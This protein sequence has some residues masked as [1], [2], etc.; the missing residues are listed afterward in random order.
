[1]KK[2]LL[3]EL[4]LREKIG[5]MLLPYQYHIYCYEDSSVKNIY[6]EKTNFTNLRSEEEVKEYIQKENF[7]TFYFEQTNFL[8]VTHMDLTDSA[9]SK[10][11]SADFKKFIM[12]QDSYSNIPA[13]MSG[14]FEREGA[15]NRF[16]DLSVVCP[17][18]AVGAT[19]SEE[20][21]YQLGAQIAKEIRS[22]GAN[23]RWAPVVDICHRF[24]A[25]SMRTFSPD[26]PDKLIRLANAHIKGMQDNGV[27]ATAKHFPGGDRYDYRDAHISPSVISSDMDEWWREQGKIFKGV[28]DAGVYSV[29]ISHSGFPAVDDSILKGNFRPA[30][31]S[32]KIV[33]DLLKGELGFKGVAVTDGIPMAGLMGCYDSYEKLMID[34]VNAGNDVLLGVFPGAG[35]IIE[36]AV[37]DGVISE[38]RIDDACQRVLDMKEKIGLFKDDYYEPGFLAS[39]VVPKTQE[40]NKKIAESAVTL[41]RDTQNLIPVDKSKIKN[42]TIICSA[43]LDKFSKKD[44]FTEQ[45]GYMKKL[46]E[47]RGMN[48]KLEKRINDPLDMER[49]DKEN[50]LIIYAA[51]VAGHQPMGHLGLYGKE[52]DTYHYAFSQGQKKSIG[53]SMGYPYLHYDLMGNAETFFNLYGRAPELMEAF[54]K[55]IFGEIEIKGVS[56]IKIEPDQIWY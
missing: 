35:D 45:M 44:T 56:P 28:I 17:P 40:L 22:A 42:V 31:V 47:E 54:V 13:L 18:L 27:A 14:D 36:K 23:W 43:H 9:E 48:V 29:M 16:S 1:M 20:M 33:T 3:S 26:D 50:D 10:P 46:L 34:L 2:P 12:K 37:N 51:Y 41:V 6:D 24:N 7:G 53:V 19:N 15:G 21:A 25:T 8:R 39:D 49:V 55:A 5:Q 38:A 4:T 30:T 11:N 32:K 52:C